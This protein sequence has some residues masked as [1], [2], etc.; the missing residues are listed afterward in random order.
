MLEVAYNGVYILDAVVDAYTS[1]SQ[2]LSFS[3]WWRSK[4]KS[5][6]SETVLQV[7]IHR[8]GEG[9]RSNK[10]VIHGTP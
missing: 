10:E 4:T 5:E 2:E 7:L 6:K 1:T 8:Y 3:E 9:F